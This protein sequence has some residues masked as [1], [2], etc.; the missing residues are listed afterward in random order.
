MFAAFNHRGKTAVNVLVIIDGPGRGREHEVEFAL[1]TGKLPFLQHDRQ[2]PRSSDARK[3][4][5]ASVRNMAFFF[6]LSFEA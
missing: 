6:R 4:V 3:P 5:K 2:E 1:R